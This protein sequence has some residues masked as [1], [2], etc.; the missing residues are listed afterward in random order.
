MA[1]TYNVSLPALWS[2]DIYARDEAEALEIAQEM[3]IEANARLWKESV[4]VY[5][6]E[7]ADS[8]VELVYE[9]EDE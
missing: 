3:A 2:V 8:L 9:E 1:R 6:H 5:H 7:G 4:Y